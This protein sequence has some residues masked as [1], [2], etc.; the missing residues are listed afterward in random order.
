[1]QLAR[2]ARLV[3]VLKQAQYEPQP[4]GQ[5]VVTIF[6]ATNGFCDGFEVAS[7]SRYE[8]ELSAFMRDK[9]GAVLAELV[10]KKTIDDAM[11]AKLSAALEEFRG[12]FRE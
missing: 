3:E 8:T 4:V 2:G 11:K 5:Q 1:M 7:L 9:N 6:A 10:E 12:V